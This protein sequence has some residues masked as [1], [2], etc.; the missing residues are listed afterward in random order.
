MTYQNGKSFLKRNRSII[1][2]VFL[3]IYF[4]V[5]NL[6]INNVT[7]SK[8]FLTSPPTVDVVLSDESTTVSIVAHPINQVV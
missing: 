2:A 3:Q 5:K 6:I 4:Y 8:N 7:K 1:I